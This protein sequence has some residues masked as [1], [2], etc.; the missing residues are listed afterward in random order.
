LNLFDSAAGT[1]VLP[2]VDALLPSRITRIIHE[3]QQ[4]KARAPRAFWGTVLRARM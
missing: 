2:I 3:L 4:V 1:W